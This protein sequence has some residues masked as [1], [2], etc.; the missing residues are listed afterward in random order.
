MPKGMTKRRP[1]TRARLLEAATEVFAERG[2]HGTSIEDIC[3]HAGY[4]RGAFYSNFG[5]KDELLLVL[6][7]ANS[8][9]V[10]DRLRAVE[11]PEGDTDVFA[12]AVA[13]AATPP[14][15]DRTW[16]LITTEFTLYAVRNPRAAAAL[17]ERDARLRTSLAE[18]LGELYT[19]AGAT[20]AV[21]LE[22]LA[23]LVVAVVEGARAQSH[24]EPDA[25]P[26]GRL[27]Q[28]FLPTVLRALAAPRR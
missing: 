11:L 20:P 1:Q 28:Q 12:A 23:R 14:D 4:T 16:F 19:R 17:N 7:D 22:D 13:A 26:P 24:L 10:L 21:D 25:L 18:L 2:F 3:Q 6:F 9:R 5:S 27:E 8:E 15:D